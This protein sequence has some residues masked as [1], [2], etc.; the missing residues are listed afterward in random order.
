MISYIKNVP[1]Y[2]WGTILCIVFC[3]GS[4]FVALHLGAYSDHA[5]VEFLAVILFFI[6]IKSIH[7]C[8]KAVAQTHQLVCAN[9]ILDRKINKLRKSLEEY[10]ERKK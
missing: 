3:I 1:M 9:I 5:F 7:R 4:A 10:F 8:A 2:M 6:N